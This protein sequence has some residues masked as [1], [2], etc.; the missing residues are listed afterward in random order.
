MVVL[1]SILRGIRLHPV[2][3]LFLAAGF[4]TFPL[5]FSYLLDLVPAQA[6]FAIAAGVS[7][8]LVGGYLRAAAGSFMFRVATI[9]QFAYMVLFSASFFFKGLTGLTLTLGGVSTLAVLM[10]LTARVDWSTRLGGL[11]PKLA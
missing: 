9:A 10:L 7:L 2:N 3:Y 8:L 11:S 5:L 4:F 6:G 1:T